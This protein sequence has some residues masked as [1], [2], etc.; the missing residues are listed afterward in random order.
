MTAAER[1]YRALAEAG[2]VTLWLADAEGRIRTLGGGWEA[3][4]GQP[5]D[6]V[7]GRRRGKPGYQD[8]AH[9]PDSETLPGLI[10]YRV[11]APLFFANARF[12]R[13]QLTAFKSSITSKC[14]LV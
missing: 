11:D 3:L 9:R 12:L 10:I 4:T 7:L 13:E 6:A 8:I 5:H 2:A 14:S 1:R